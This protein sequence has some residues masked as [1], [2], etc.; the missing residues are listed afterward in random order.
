MK[1][2]KVLEKADRKSVKANI[3]TGDTRQVPAVI[4]C[5]NKCACMNM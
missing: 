5:I 2:E 4:K 1:S 3:E